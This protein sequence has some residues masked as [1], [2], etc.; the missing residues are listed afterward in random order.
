[1]AIKKYVS[2]DNLSKFLDNNKNMFSTK[3]KR[4]EFNIYSLSIY[5]IN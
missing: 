5:F 2:F 4:V 3:N 1:M